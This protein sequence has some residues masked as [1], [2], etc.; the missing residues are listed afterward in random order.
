LA[1]Y[2]LRNALGFHDNE[3]ASYRAFKEQLQNQAMIDIMNAGYIIYDGDKGT[4]VQK[5]PGDLGRARLYYNFEAMENQEKIIQKLRDSDF[6]YRNVLL[7]DAKNL[8]P[9]QEGDGS[10]KIVSTK[11]DKL[12]FEVESSQNALLFVSENFHKY[13]KAKVNGKDAQIY[14]AFSTFMAF[15]IP[16]GKSIVELQYKS[17]NVKISLWIGLAGVLLL[18]GVAVVLRFL[19]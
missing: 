11:M 14:R 2:G 10:L 4:G 6:D 16:Q 13:W 9:L 15:D 1:S 17:D 3:I 18:V 19:P 12:K 5:N 8:L 7:L